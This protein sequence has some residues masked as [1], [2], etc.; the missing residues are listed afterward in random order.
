MLYTDDNEYGEWKEGLLPA[1]YR[2]FTS[3]DLRIFHQS[4]KMEISLRE[5]S[6]RNLTRIVQYSRMRAMPNNLYKY[7]ILPVHTQTHMNNKY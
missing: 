5:L 2:L 4:R 7:L 1:K 6:C 3:G